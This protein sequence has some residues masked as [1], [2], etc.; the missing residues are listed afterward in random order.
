MSNNSHLT[1]VAQ[2]AALRSVLRS[3]ASVKPAP[4]APS[5]VSLHGA[6]HQFIVKR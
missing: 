2:T 5:F 4:L 3:G 6:N 1:A